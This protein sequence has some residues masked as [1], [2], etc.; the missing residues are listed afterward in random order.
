MFSVPVK[1][2]PAALLSLKLIALLMVPEEV[3]V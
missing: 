2:A 1:F 3:M